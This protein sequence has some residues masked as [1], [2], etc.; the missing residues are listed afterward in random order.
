MSSM[1]SSICATSGRRIRRAVIKLNDSFSGEGNAVFTFPESRSRDAVHEA[2]QHVSI[3]APD[4]TPRA[5][6]DEFATMGGIVEEFIDAEETAFAE[7]AVSHQPVRRRRADLDARPDSRWAVRPGLSGL[8]ISRARRLS[9]RAPGG[10]RRAS[11]APL[12]RTASSAASASTSSRTGTVRPTV[13]AHGARDQPARGRHD[14]PVPRAEIPERRQA[15]SP[16]RDS[17][18]RSAAAPS[19]TSRPTT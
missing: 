1:R 14:A 4:Q 17:S 15:R 2:L 18:T 16:D 7:R 19:T 6:L 13:D 8:P 5:Y 10:G 9:C 3:C 12:P 11:A